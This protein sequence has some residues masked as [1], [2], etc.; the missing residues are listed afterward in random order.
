[1]NSTKSEIYCTG[2]GYSSL[3]TRQS[4][5]LMYGRTIESMDVVRT[6]EVDQLADRVSIRYR[7]LFWAE[8][9]SLSL[10]R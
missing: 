6:G 3:P 9:S 10:F 8:P 7:P 4:E 1:M 2:V 5:D